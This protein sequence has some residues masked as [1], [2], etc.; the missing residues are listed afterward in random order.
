MIS[1]RVRAVLGVWT[2][3]AIG[4]AIIATAINFYFTADLS[5]GVFA[6][7]LESWR[8]VC[9]AGAFF[10]G[11]VMVLSTYGRYRKA[12]AARAAA[13]EEPPKGPA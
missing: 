11:S 2:P 7:D 6:E 3:M 12:R 9:T 1:E 10:L 8:L 13:R 4:L 5:S